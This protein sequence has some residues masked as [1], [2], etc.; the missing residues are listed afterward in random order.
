MR[1]LNKYAIGLLL[2]KPL[3]IGLPAVSAH[4]FLPPVY[5]VEVMFS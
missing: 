2:D 5:A 4:L 1:A 3:A